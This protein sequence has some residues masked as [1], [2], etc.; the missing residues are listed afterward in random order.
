MLEQSELKSVQSCLPPTNSRTSIEIHRKISKCKK[1]IDPPSLVHI[2]EV[3]TNEMKSVSDKLSTISDQL[4]QIITL[5]SRNQSIEKSKHLTEIVNLQRRSL[6]IE[7]SPICSKHSPA[8]SLKE[9]EEE[10]IRPLLVTFANLA[11][12]GNGSHK[13]KWK[14]RNRVEF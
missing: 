3:M 7:E 6:S 10:N 14:D 5:L 9:V 13:S 1:S 2:E 4:A 11:D 12:A 8:H